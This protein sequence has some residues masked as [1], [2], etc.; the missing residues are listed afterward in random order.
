MQVLRTS[1][2]NLHPEQRIYRGKVRDVYWVKD[3]IILVSSDRISAFDHILHEAIPFKGQVLN[4]V[5]AFFLEKTQSVVPNWFERSPDPNVSMGKSCEPIRLEMVV[6]GYLVGH[7]WREYRAGKRRI[8]GVPMPEGMKENDAFPAPIITPATKAEEGHDEDISKEQILSRKIA[9]PEVYEKL[10]DYSLKLFELGSKMA[11]ERGLI[12]VDTKYEFG[13]Y[14][15]EILLMDEVHTPDSSR[16]FYR[17]GYEERQKRGERQ[18]QLSKEFVRE[19]LIEQGFQGREGQELP[20]LPPEFVEEVS[21][22]YI[23]LYETI[24]GQAFVREETADVNRRIQENLK[25]H[26]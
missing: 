26:L 19:W 10:Q 15:D 11:N 21:N 20:H 16:Y 18:K 23:E 4:Q 17:E 6:R 5:S 7:A 25:V 14:D 22:R 13:F 8:C 1:R 3:K 9:A 24:T 12:L 2:L